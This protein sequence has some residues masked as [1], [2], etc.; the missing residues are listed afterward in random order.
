MKKKILIAFSILVSVALNYSNLNAQ[1]YNIATEDG[2]TVNTC[3]GAFTDSDA[4]DDNGDF[5]YLNNESYMVTFCSSIPGNCLQ[6]DF[7]E[8][9]I[10]DGQDW[11]YVWDGADTASGNYIGRYNNPF[12]NNTNNLSVLYPDGIQS[13]TGCF[14]FV[15]ISDSDFIVG[16]GWSAVITCIDDCPTCYDGIQNGMETDVDCDGVCLDCPDPVNIANGGTV[17]TCDNIFV[18]SGGLTGDYETSENYTMTICSDNPNPNYCLV[19]QFAQWNVASGSSMNIYNGTTTTASNLIGTYTGGWNPN[20]PG[21]IISDEGC[22]TITFTS[23]GW[24]TDDGWVANIFCQLCEEE[25]IPTTADCLGALPI[26][27]INDMQTTAPTGS[28]NYDDIL[29]A[30]SCLISDNNVVWYV[31]DITSAGILNF[32]LNSVPLTNNY[33]WALMNIT[34]TSCDDLSAS[35]LI[36][37][38]SYSGSGPTGISTALGG[39]GA[40]N[41]LIPYNADV[42]VNA[43]QTY[44]LAITSVGASSGFDLDFSASTAAVDDNT[45]PS[46]A[47]VLP[48]CANNSLEVTFSEPVLCS[49]I[50][51][52]DFLVVGQ[53]LTA[54]ISSIESAWCDNGLDGGVEFVMFL[55]TVL[56]ENTTYVFS[57]ES[58]GGG[59]SDICGNMNSSESFPFQT[60][61]AMTLWTDITPSDCAESIPTGEVDIIVNGGVAPFYLEMLNQYGYDDSVF[62]FVNLPS[63]PIPVDVFDESGCHAIFT[64]DVPNSNSNMLNTVEVGNVSCLGGDGFIEVSTVGLPGY[65]PWKYVIT[66]SL[67]N[68]M[69]VANNNNYVYV[70]NLNI[71]EYTVSITDLSGLSQCPDL[72][73][74]YV[75]EPDSI[76]LTTVNDT[77]ICYYGETYLSSTVSGGTGSPFT[78]HWD[79]GATQ[80]TTVP[81]QSVTH[82]SLITTTYYDVYAEDDLGCTSEMYQV[83]VTVNDLLSFDMDP[84]QLIC[85]GTQTYLSVEN[86]SGGEGFGYNVVWDLGNGLIIDQDSV[87]VIPTDPS[88]YCV[89]VTDQCET[90]NVDS[91]IVVSPTLSIPVTFIVTSDTASCPPYLA[92]FQNTTNPAYVASA[93]WDFGD[94][95]SDNGITSVNHIF[96]QSGNY[97]VTLSITDPDGCTFD[98]TIVDLITMYPEPV[99]Q[100]STDPQN[101]TIINSTVQFINESEGGVEFYWLFDTINQLGEAH[102]ENPFFVFPDQLPQEYFNRLSVTN[103]FGCEDMITQMLVIE[104]D[105]TLYVPNSFSPNGDGK[106][107]FFFVK[108][109][110]LDPIFFQLEIYDRWGNLVFQ[111]NDINEK[112]NG[113]INGGEYYSQPG[114]FVYNLSYKI[115]NSTE[116]QNKKGMITLIR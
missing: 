62:T 3:V 72:Q 65:G 109:L 24:G 7:T 12:G 78:L 60:G 101:P 89:T 95:Q 61:E 46:V 8:F 51:E 97:D 27:G 18:D 19:L 47:N 23:G 96:E 1:I 58:S 33:N 52:M 5:V 17:S 39:V 25:P 73:F 79:N 45:P 10:P 70:G 106:N 40:T 114:V 9:D 113:S 86:I 55:D 64:I 35:T 6:L 38:N 82:D 75:N 74:V 98:S 14:T 4:F 16:S 54:G 31:F 93:I 48:N 50:S 102:V 76:L 2:G 83:V 11:L 42:T 43:G 29:P 71:G 41:S 59:I 111:S 88:T 36:S 84:D 26:C 69:A 37:C 90:P 103:E 67:G 13:T 68:T 105:L 15:F 56:N 20:I 91:C 44:A 53:F 116:K 100:F 107:D 87:L 99:A 32:S 104:E 49:S 21:T 34:N 112:W 66:D 28:G 108:G 85:A 110:E 30:N 57:V 63:G 22:L 81:G 92:S 80:F 94:G 77:S 115:S